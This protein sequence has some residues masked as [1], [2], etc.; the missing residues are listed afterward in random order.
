MLAALSAN[1]QTAII[2][3]AASIV[4][5]TVAAAAA[6]YSSRIRIREI[7]LTYEQ[8]LHENYLASAR[9][10]TTTIISP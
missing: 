3:A 6:T 1:A 2:A 9:T 4:A 5:A 7:R 10:Y 8:K